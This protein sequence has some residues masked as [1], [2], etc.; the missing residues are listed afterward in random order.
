MTVDDWIRSG[1]M[2]NMGQES[3]ETGRGNRKKTDD[4]FNTR[5]NKTQF[6]TKRHRHRH[7]EENI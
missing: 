4:T 5:V 7:V 3:S 2:T 1:R 6:L